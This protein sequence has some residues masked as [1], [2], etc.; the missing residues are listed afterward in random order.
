MVASSP[1]VRQWLERTTAR[2]LE[3]GLDEVTDLS[4]E[5][6]R[7]FL[8]AHHDPIER[9]FEQLEDAPDKTR[10]LVE[11]L[12]Q[13]LDKQLGADLHEQA[14]TALG[15]LR[16]LNVKL[17]RLSSDAALE[18]RELLERRIVRI[19]RTLEEERVPELLDLQVR[20]QKTDA[21]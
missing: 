9:A 6:F 5:Q 10:E 20:E 3:Y 21:G 13:G 11:D 1:E 18:P 15:L 12:E 14:R 8:Q 19:L 2:Q 17:E 4:A 7:A 16:Q